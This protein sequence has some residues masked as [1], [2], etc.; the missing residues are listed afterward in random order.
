LTDRLIAFIID[1]GNF[2]PSQTSVKSLSLPA[3]YLRPSTVFLDDL[4]DNSIIEEGDDETVNSSGPK[5]SIQLSSSLVKKIM[6]DNSRR[7]S[8]MPQRKSNGGLWSRL[9]QFSSVRPSA[10]ESFF[11]NDSKV[12]QHL[13]SPENLIPVIVMLSRHLPTK[14]GAYAPSSAAL[15]TS[16]HFDNENFDAYRHCLG[17]GTM[18]SYGQ[19]ISL[20]RNKLEPNSVSVQMSSHYRDT[21]L[22]SDIFQIQ[23]QDITSFLEGVPV[24]VTPVTMTSV[25]AQ[26]QSRLQHRTCLPRIKATYTQITFQSPAHDH[27][28]V[29]VKFN[30]QFF[31]LWPAQSSPPSAIHLDWDHDPTRYTA[32]DL[33]SFPWGV[34]E[35]HLKEPFAS[36][37][38]PFLEDLFGLSLLF[39]PQVSTE[40]FSIY[41]HALYSF[42]STLASSPVD[43]SI[44]PCPS[45]WE[46]LHSIDDL[47]SLLPS[48]QSPQ[49]WF[50]RL[51]HNILSLNP[52]YKS[53]VDVT[54]ELKLSFQKI[55]FS[56]ERTFL[57]W[58]GAASYPVTLGLLISRQPGAGV[59]GGILVLG[60]V[61]IVVY[62]IVTYILRLLALDKVKAVTEDIQFYDLYGPVCL[63]LFISVS[64]T[65]SW[66]IIIGVM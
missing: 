13:I 9:S 60:G 8:F 57:S 48:Q 6:H 36:S 61:V 58:L 54:K 40:L 52:N 29:T 5:S 32:R 33:I 51:I 25:S 37:P 14:S 7:L 56:C 39:Q 55:F 24:S 2:L 41:S 53:S 18:Q 10:R 42:R 46:E 43:A 49:H 17:P 44:L 62:A 3:K 65:I 16:F 34:I 66:L 4:F 27:V 12:E 50:A 31:N 23:A 30:Y 11:V 21:Q 47:A 26:V 63:S 20:H 64:W 35:I 59:P 15:M 45:W 38:P 22:I 19:A 28:L 1:S